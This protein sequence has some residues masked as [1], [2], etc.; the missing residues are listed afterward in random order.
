MTADA[1]G[2]DRLKR[3]PRCPSYFSNSGGSVWVVPSSLAG[4][5]ANLRLSPIRENRPNHFPLKLI[6]N[7]KRSNFE[8]RTGWAEYRGSE[9]NGHFG[10][11]WG[12]SASWESRAGVGN[13]Y[14][15]WA[16]FPARSPG[17]HTT[18]ACVPEDAP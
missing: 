3:T 11:K 12:G 18:V 5:G 1:G 6:S 10:E 8:N 16:K 4:T 13:G 9:R 17:E 7:S 14:C 2:L 15:Y